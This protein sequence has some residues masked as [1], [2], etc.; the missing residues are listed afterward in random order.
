[1]AEVELA[2]D[3]YGIPEIAA[4]DPEGL[5]FGLGYAHAADRLFQLEF[6]R[7]AAAGRLTELLGPTALEADRFLRR[8]GLVGRARQD[9]ETQ[10]PDAARLLRAY[11]AGVN[12]RL[13]KGGAAAVPEF[14]LLNYEPAPWHPVDSLAVGR[15]IGWMLSANWE[16]ELAR[17]ELVRRLG[18]ERAARLEPLT[19]PDVYPCAADPVPDPAAVRDQLLSAYTRL[20]AILPLGAASNA[21]AVG[22]HRSASERPLL[23]SDPH[24]QPQIPVLWYLVRLRTPEFWAAGASIPGLFG[25]SIGRSRQCAWG[26]TVAFADTQD[27]FIEE[28]RPGPA[29]ELLA[30]TADGWEPVRSRVETFRAGGSVRREVCRETRRG[31]LILDELPYGLSL[32]ASALRAPVDGGILYRLLVARDCADIEAVVR[33]WT[34]PAL[35]FIIADAAGNIAHFMA[36]RIPAR[37][38]RGGAVPAPAWDPEAAWHGWVEPERLPRLVN[39]PSGFVFSANEFPALAATGEYLGVDWPDPHRAARIY[40]LLDGRP[41]HSARD[42]IAYQQDL[43][44]I[45]LSRLRDYVIRAAGSLPDTVRRLLAEWD[46]TVRADS[47]AAGF[48][49]VLRVELVRAYFEAQGLDPAT[50]DLLLGQGLHPF[51]PVNGFAGRLSSFLLTGLGQR[52]FDG[53]LEEAMRRTVA[54]WERRAGRNPAGWRWGKV[55]RLRFTHPLGTLPGLGRLWRGPDRPVWGDFDTVCQASFLPPAAFGRAGW[56]ANYRQVIDL[57]EPE[58]GY[59]VTNTG[60][61]GSPLSRHYLDQFRLWYRGQYLRMGPGREVRRLRL[62]FRPP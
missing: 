37:K 38:D 62:D 39:P 25:L 36:G 52:L 20:A 2:F 9:W 14:W 7:L 13:E 33:N 35:N 60:Q 23:A 26:V 48:L 12:A 18:P 58:D 10:P 55:H 47:A 45:P 5:A 1:M 4:P 17:L 42:F 27:L 6:H 29:G 32:A 61:A 11:T 8:L 44:S 28:I 43:V 40:A 21:W 41:R 15:L 56:V 22:P 46:G 24:L 54:F 16:T 50:T 34:M 53:V 49:E 57:A 59:W 19:P 30:R 3:R 31:P 51:A